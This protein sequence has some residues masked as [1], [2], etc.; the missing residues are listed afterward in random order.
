MP[1]SDISNEALSDATAQVLQILAIALKLKE[2][3]TDHMKIAVEMGNILSPN[4]AMYG[5][6]AT[7]IHLVLLSVAME[8]LEHLDPSQKNFVSAPE[9]KN[10]KAND[11]RIKKHP[12][13]EKA[14]LF[15]RICAD[16]SRHIAGLSTGGWCRSSCADAGC[17]WL[18]QAQVKGQAFTEEEEGGGVEIV[19]AG[20]GGDVAP[21]AD[22][23]SEM[24]KGKGKEG[25]GKGKGKAKDVA[26]PEDDSTPSRS[27]D[28]DQSN[29]RP[30][31]LMAIPKKQKVAQSLTTQ[32]GDLLKEDVNA[33]NDGPELVPRCEQCIKVYVLVTIHGW[34]VLILHPASNLCSR[35]KAKCSHVKGGNPPKPTSINRRTPS[36]SQQCL[37]A[38][39]MLESDDAISGPA[40][41]VHSVP[42]I[43]ILATDRSSLEPAQV[44]SSLILNPLS[45]SLLDHM[46]VDMLGDSMLHELQAMTLEV[47]QDS[48]AMHAKS[49]GLQDTV[50]HLRSEVN[51]LEA[52][53]LATADLVTEMNQCLAVQEIDILKV[54]QEDAATCDQQLQ[55]AE[56]QLARQEHTTG[57]LQ[58]GY[59]ALRQ[60][61]MAPNQ[62]FAATPFPNGVFLTNVPYSSNQS[63]IP[64]SVAQ[65]QALEALY[66]NMPTS[67][68]GLGGSFLGNVAGGSQT[69][70]VVGTNVAGSSQMNS[71][72]GTNLASGS[73]MNSVVGTNVTRWFPDG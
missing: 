32:V 48:A 62:S 53:H 3:H 61:V 22:K 64:L 33:D 67:A 71:V 59:N 45:D 34:R 13:A 12:L 54:L 56:E 73:Q 37:A 40:L 38:E 10:I 27:P 58:D 41:V 49:S 14:H 18:I 30:T 1:S 60:C 2:G 6:L 43:M 72:V 20:D 52:R 26:P 19:P 9:W 63:V 47:R 70:S 51:K 15:F 31:A 29:S 65:T 66:L 17:C 57:L 46:E 11:P 36:S 16:P 25:K 50:N 24:A 23:P 35:S 7:S 55:R 8:L 68:S 5:M 28:E 4:F 21:A 44:S 42:P 39:D 69:N